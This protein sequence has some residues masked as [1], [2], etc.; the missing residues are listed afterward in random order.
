[1]VFPDFQPLK[2]SEEPVCIYLFRQNPVFTSLHLKSPVHV[3]VPPLF[4]SWMTLLLDRKEVK[5]FE[6]LMQSIKGFQLF[7]ANHRHSVPFLC[8]NKQISS[9]LIR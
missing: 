6:S 8:E 4:M 3:V 7:I 2:V 9:L 5:K 1:V